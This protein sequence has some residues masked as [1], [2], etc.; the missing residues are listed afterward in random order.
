VWLPAGQAPLCETTQ[1][2]PGVQ[3]SAAVAFSVIFA[4][5]SFPSTRYTDTLYA[6]EKEV[7]LALFSRVNPIPA[8]STWVAL[9]GVEELQRPGFLVDSHILTLESPFLAFISRAGAI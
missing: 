6:S 3:F 8:A 9:R 7:I 1:A 2:G 4:V 5:P